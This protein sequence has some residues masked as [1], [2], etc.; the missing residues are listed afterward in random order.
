[1]EG[2]ERILN[3]FIAY[4][5]ETTEQV[6]AVIVL[7]ENTGL[8]DWVRSMADQLAA[9]GYLAIVP[10]LLSSFSEKIN[11]TTDFP[12]PD[13]ARAAIYRL[14]RDQITKDLNAV[15]HRI[16]NDTICNGQVSIIGFGWGGA[17][18]FRYASNNDQLKAA[19]VFYGPPPKTVKEYKAIQ[20]PV[21]GFFGG[22]DQSVN[23]TLQSTETIM[24][25]N[26]K[27]FEPV[28]YPRAVHGFMRIGGAPKGGKANKK[29][30]KKAWKRIVSLLSGEGKL[31]K[32]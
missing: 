32:P 14:D 29:A 11:R 18:S 1:M 4:P 7:H 27:T 25:H 31:K 17:Q 19:L 15:F 28:V 22:E 24:T 21:Y 9:K 30:K 2:D 16:K 10:D 8:T 20:V 3:C 12:T 23:A 6:Q 13:E 5:E 26:N